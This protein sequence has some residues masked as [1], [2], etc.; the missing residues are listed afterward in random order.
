PE[1]AHALAQDA[2]AW[3]K[4]PIETAPAERA[5]VAEAALVVNATPIGTADPQATPWPNADDFSP[6]QTVYDL[7]YRPARTRLL[8]DA[9]A[10]GA[11]R[12]GGLPMLVAQAAASFRLWTGLDM[13]TAAAERAAR[14]ALD[15]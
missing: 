13:D 2:C 14:T 8:L 4:V 10:R 11:R 1:R 3:G 5:P 6:H 7:V 15:P 12:I 9:E